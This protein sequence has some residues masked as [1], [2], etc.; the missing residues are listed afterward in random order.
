MF[1]V[2]RVRDRLQETLNA[3]A[4]DKKEGEKIKEQVVSS[5]AKF[6]SIDLFTIICMHYMYEQY[7][8]GYSVRRIVS[9]RKSLKM[10]MLEIIETY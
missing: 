6:F 1:S 8:R 10:R 2:I 5:L 3:K 4:E 7:V 9:I